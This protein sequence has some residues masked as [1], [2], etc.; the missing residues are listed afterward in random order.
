MVAFSLLVVIFAGWMLTPIMLAHYPSAVAAVP[1]LRD[2]I[3]QSGTPDPEPVAESMAAPEPSPANGI[4]LNAEPEPAPA[5][6]SPPATEARPA[7]ADSST[8]STHPDSPAEAST[9]AA[10]D[11]PVALAVPPGLLPWPDADPSAA[12]T[13]PVVAEVT[14]GTLGEPI[15]AAP[16][17]LPR[18]RPSAASLARLTVP[19]PRPRP[20]EAPSVA[21]ES[22]IPDDGLFD[23]LTRPN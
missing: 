3:G 9:Q 11:M 2:L 22:P 18:P 5:F 20:D 16:V 15:D 17:P 23:R 7:P 8:E 12:P 6:P 19:V 1:L 21:E 14:T 13:E 4:A 10:V